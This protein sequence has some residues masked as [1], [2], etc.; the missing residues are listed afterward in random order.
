MKRSKADTKKL[1]PFGPTIAGAY[2]L[3]GIAIPLTPC[4]GLT[5]CN[6]PGSLFQPLHFLILQLDLFLPVRI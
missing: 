3:L 4:D 1:S 6:I 5:E 2:R